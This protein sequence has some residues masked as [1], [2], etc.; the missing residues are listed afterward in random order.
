MRAESLLLEPMYAA[1]LEVPSDRL[2]R[3]LSD[4][5]RM[6]ATFDPPEVT[7]DVARI[8]ARVPVSEIADYAMEVQ[9]YTSGRGHLFLEPQGYETAHDAE[10]VVEEAAY[11][12]EADLAH[13][14][15]SVFCSHGAGYTVKWHEVEAHAH[16]TP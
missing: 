8:I 16:L 5:Q 6:S 4:L 15:D 3:A 11:D 1:E 9:A 7:G 14:P 2:G 12:P 13:T 10:R